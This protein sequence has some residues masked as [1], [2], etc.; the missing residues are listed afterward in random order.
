[1]VYCY[2]RTVFLKSI[3]ASDVIRDYKYLYRQIVEVIKQV[4][5]S[6]VVQIVTDNGSNFKNVDKRIMFK[7]PIFWTSCAVHCIDLILKDF[8]KT[9]LVEKTVRK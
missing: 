3:D 4:G 8:G 5:P 6:N 7:Y 1:M 9:K 2:D